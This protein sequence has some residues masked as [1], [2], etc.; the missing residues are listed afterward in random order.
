ME[1]RGFLPLNK[2]CLA[3]VSWRVVVI[4]GIVSAG[5][6]GWYVVLSEAW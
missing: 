3:W 4:V 5:G 6:L 1:K 2:D